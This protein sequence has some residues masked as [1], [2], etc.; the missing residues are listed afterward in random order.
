MVPEKLRIMKQS[1]LKSKLFYYLLFY[2]AICPLLLEGQI[3]D[4]KFEHLST[5][6]GLSQ[7]SV[8]AILQDQTGFLWLGTGDGL[9]RYDGYNYL[10]Y[11]KIPQNSN[12]LSHN[13]IWSL[14]ED[15][16]GIIWIGTDMG[17]NRL[18]PRVEQFTR[19]LKNPY[20]SNS[21]SENSVRA[22]LEDSHDELWVGTNRGLNRLNRQTGEFEHFYFIEGDNNSLSDSRI[23]FL[24]ESSGGTLWIGTYHGLNR[25]DRITNSFTRYF[26]NPG[27]STAYSQNRIRCMV[28]DK[29]GLLW[30]GTNAGLHSFDP[31]T[32]I[33]DPD[34][35][36]YPRDSVLCG[37]SIRSLL[38][39]QS[40]NLWVGTTSGLSRYDQELKAFFCHRFD[41]QNQYSLSINEIRSLYQDRGGIVWIG[42]YM[43][44]LNKFDYNKT[45]FAH[46]HK[47]NS[48]PAHINHNEVR[49]FHEDKFGQI[50]IGTNGGGLNVFDRQARSYT[51]FMNIRNKSTSIGSNR[52]YAILKDRKGT[53]WL[54]TNGNGIE[55]VILSR[56]KNQKIIGFEHFRHDP[57]DPFSLSSDRIRCLIEDHAG[58]I[59]IGTFDRGLS[60]FDPITQ[61]FLNFPHEPDNTSSLSNNTVYSLFEDS[62]NVLWVGT[63]SGLNRYK[64][65][66]GCF[67]RYRTLLDDPK[68]LSDESI[69]SIH[70]DNSG[71]LWFG[72]YAG[73]NKFDRENETFIHYMEG[74]GLTNDVVYGILEDKQGFFWLSTNKGVAKFDPITETSKSY[75]TRDGL[76][77]EEFAIGAFYKS[78][79]GQM[80]FGGNKGYNAFWPENIEDNPNTPPVVFTDFQLFNVSLGIGGN[81][82]WPLKKSITFSDAI[83]L[84]HRENSI[85]FEFS[86]LDF[87]APEKNQYAYILEGFESEWTFTKKRHFVAYTNLPHGKYTLRLKG[88]NDNGIWNVNETT[89]QINI[90]PPFWKMLGSQII[91]GFFIIGSVLLAYRLRIRSMKTQQQK[92]ERQV[93]ERTEELSLKTQQV[94]E[95]KNRLEELL[96]ELQETQSQLIQSAKMASLGDLVAGILHEFNSPM[97][98]L[99]GSLDVST[100]GLNKILD[101]L[102]KYCSSE[103]ISG[104]KAMQRAISVMR[105]NLLTS[106]NACDRLEAIIAGLRSFA[107]MDS[108][109]LQQMDINSGIESALSML[110]KEM[111]NR[112]SVKKEFFEIPQIACHPCEINQVFLNLIRNAIQA[113]ENKGVI[114]IRTK[115]TAADI[116][117]EIEDTGCGMSPEHLENLFEINFTESQSR[118]KLGLGLA[119]SYQVISRHNGEIHV[120]SQEGKGSKFTITLPIIQLV[121]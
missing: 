56:S 71:N 62:R 20:R 109:T 91:I 34:G 118:V 63:R 107:M 33:F 69:L 59:W 8:R 73:L 81:N 47:D 38:M 116:V 10:I 110:N 74:I 13:M 28:Q 82:R 19:Y 112:I 24:F 114:T 65:E 21:L 27:D 105:E 102:D 50:W 11:K 67:V 44:G 104:D 80:F 57:E 120:E 115:N 45:K 22:V 86:A 64:P 3:G 18:D 87:A 103:E 2:L 89:L 111:G 17:L 60:R 100:R 77:S 53:F 93:A 78:P 68:S 90:V 14:W 31:E 4:A 92:L 39:D 106:S 101:G 16:A 95:Q 121:K 84:N 6:D 113:I 15:R 70:E 46:Y 99:Q 96:N 26:P 76:Q 83:K 5:N 66:L 25:Y 88:S 36:I 61:T 51:Y 30:I 55:K 12:S 23:R 75:D 9:N 37:E 108:M 35:T 98:A 97:G 29:N 117:I 40:G 7:S 58:I 52:I 54:G 48:Y 119:I 32:E 1:P 42:T 49:A 79:S 85:A 94:L 41:S 43:G 72:T